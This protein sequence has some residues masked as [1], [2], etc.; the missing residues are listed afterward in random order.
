MEWGND[1]IDFKGKPQ[2]GSANLLCV[3]LLVYLMGLFC[4]FFVPSFAS[5]F[6]CSF[7]VCGF[8]GTT[9]AQQVLLR[10][11]IRLKL[12]SLPLF[13]CRA[14]DRNPL[15]RQSPE[16]LSLSIPLGI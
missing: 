12:L 9:R 15:A 7:L 4:F 5:L 14:T 1:G 6:V 11:Q 13:V 3:S 8:L 10:K 2:I 16:L